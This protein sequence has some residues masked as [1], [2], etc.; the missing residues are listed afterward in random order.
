MAMYTGSCDNLILIA[1]NGDTNDSTGC[2]DNSAAINNFVVTA[3]TTYYIRIGGFQGAVGSGTF[4]VTYSRVAAWGSNVNGQCRVPQ[5]I[6]MVTKL[7]AGGDHVVA[8]NAGNQVSAWGANQFTQGTVPSTVG[9]AIEVAAG[10]A[11]SLAIR[12][13]GTVAAWGRN[14]SGQ[15]N[16][17]AT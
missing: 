2:Q 4:T 9:S 5:T 14:S 3:G 6:G 13:N 10:S 8:L 15:C 1:C 17:P 12:T 7:A 11:H 16:V